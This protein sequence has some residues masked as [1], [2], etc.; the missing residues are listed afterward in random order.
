MLSIP[1]IFIKIS[2][3]TLTRITMFLLFYLTLEFARMFISASAATHPYM[4]M[5]G[6]ILF[7]ATVVIIFN[8]LYSNNGAGRDINTLNFYGVLVH[9][10]YIPFY[11]FSIDLSMYHNYAHKA[12]N[13]LVMLRLIWLGNTEILADVA[14][15]ERGKNWVQSRRLFLNSYING[16][17]IAV[18]VLCAVP[19]CTLI[20]IIN[21]DQMRATGIAVI[22]FAFFVAFQYSKHNPAN[23]EASSVIPDT[24]T[25]ASA[26]SDSE[27]TTLLAVKVGY[28]FAVFIIASI[29]LSIADNEERFFNVG[30]ASGF[31]DAKSGA[32]PKRE[33]DFDKALW[34]NMVRHPNQPLPPGLSCDDNPPKK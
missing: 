4:A 24:Q 30:Y 31:A 15:I 20:F 14:L 21:T 22:L 13:W 11:Y 28:W 8:L 16:L 1:N 29:V 2:E 3:A 33:T 17:T 12:I 23:I 10:A 26:P 25:N 5:W 7:E 32:A 6:N 34:C 27:A 9:M 19:L 18:F